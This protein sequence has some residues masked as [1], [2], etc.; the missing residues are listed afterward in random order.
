M[1]APVATRLR[2][3]SIAVDPVA[4]TYIDAVLAHPAYQA[5]LTAAVAEP[6][7]VPQ[8]EGETPIEDLR[9]HL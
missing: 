6:W 5:W 2:T 7:I 8:N 4:Q 9:E 1:Y 3:Y